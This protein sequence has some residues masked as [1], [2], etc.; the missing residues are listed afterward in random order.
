ML[1]DGPRKTKSKSKIIN[2]ISTFISRKYFEV[3]KIT[4]Y[5]TQG[6][7]KI[8][9]VMCK[10]GV[11]NYHNLIEVLKIIIIII[12]F[13]IVNMFYSHVFSLKQ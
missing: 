10:L 9:F 3:K 6:K 11:L 5:T 4:L 8:D 13:V 7:I 1:N 12:I 2:I